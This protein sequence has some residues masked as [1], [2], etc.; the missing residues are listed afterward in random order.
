MGRL[1]RVYAWNLC[2]GAVSQVAD[3]RVV[4]PEV[5]GLRDGPP[6]GLLAEMYR[7]G[8]H[9]VGESFTPSGEGR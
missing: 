1:T 5:R 7:R 6:A 4:R 2:T 3:L 8:L 9:R